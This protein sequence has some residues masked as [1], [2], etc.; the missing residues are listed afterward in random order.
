[1]KPFKVYKWKIFGWYVM[2]SRKRIRFYPA[3][4]KDNEVGRAMNTLRD[5][6]YKTRNGCCEI[7]GQHYPKGSM[8][9]H[10]V[11]P[12]AVFVQYA[13]ETWNLLMLCPRCH[14]IVHHD[15]PMQT[16]MMLRTAN[17][18]GVDLERDYHHS[19]V[20]FWDKKQAVLESKTNKKQ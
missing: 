2:A 4:R 3:P 15:I 20:Q 10:H 9:M 7:C 6:R 19:A 8:Q 17:S 11:L 16:N 13:R 5:Q 1:M 14:F 18:H 12:Y